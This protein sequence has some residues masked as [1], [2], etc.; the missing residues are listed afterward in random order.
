MNS[1]VF[2]GMGIMGCDGTN[3][4]SG[5]H[6]VRRLRGGFDAPRE[7][8]APGYYDKCKFFKT[9]VVECGLLSV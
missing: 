5:T 6:Q 9:C 4:K 2:V 3:G 1:G 7:T 8:G